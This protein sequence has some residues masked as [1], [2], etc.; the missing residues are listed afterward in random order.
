MEA[1]RILTSLPRDCIRQIFTLLSLLLLS[2]L[3]ITCHSTFRQ[4]RIFY[5]NFIQF[6]DVYFRDILPIRGLGSV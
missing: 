4:F 6:C 3:N 5:I 2:L 1:A